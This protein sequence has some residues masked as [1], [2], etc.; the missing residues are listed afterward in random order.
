MVNAVLEGTSLWIEIALL[1][2][3]E[4]ILFCLG[5]FQFLKCSSGLKFSGLAV[6]ST[7][8]AVARSLTGKTRSARLRTNRIPITRRAIFAFLPVDALLRGICPVEPTGFAI[9]MDLDPDI[10]V[11]FLMPDQ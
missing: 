7:K 5:R 1:N 2:E 6:F 9:T 3:L 8:L 11:T 10:K 4:K